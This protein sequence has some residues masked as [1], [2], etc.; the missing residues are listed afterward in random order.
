MANI[1]SQKKRILI[2]RAENARNTS[3]KSAVKTAIKKYEATIAAGDLEQATKMLNGVYAIIDAAKSDGIFHINTAANKK[4]RMAK[5]LNAA[6][7]A[8]TE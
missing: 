7:A 4:A 1:K 6:K 2:S 5:M 8:V 3:K